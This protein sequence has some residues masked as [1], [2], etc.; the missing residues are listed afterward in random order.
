VAPPSPPPDEH[1]AP[2]APAGYGV[3]VGTFVSGGPFADAKAFVP[4]FGLAGSFGSRRGLRPALTLAL[5]YALPFETT[6]DIVGSHTNLVAPRALATLE[7]VHASWIAVDVGAGGG[8]DIMSVEPRSA[9]LP[10]ST[11]GPT[12]TRADPVLRAA[13]VARVPLVPSVVFTA[14]LAADGDLTERAYV[15][16]DGGR[17]TEVLIPWRVRP[18]LALGFAFT[19]L[20]EATFR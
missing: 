20:G 5:E 16:D 13:V 19:A 7:V 10:S 12:T 15:A 6:G 4:R 14:S 2:R 3:D 1:E 9:V 11:L 17:R 18:Q 8:L